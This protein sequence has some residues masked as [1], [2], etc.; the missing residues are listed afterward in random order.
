MRRHKL[1]LLTNFPN[2]GSMTEGGMSA[3]EWMF[4]LLTFYTAMGKLSCSPEIS[5]L[6]AFHGLSMYR[7]WQ[8][9]HWLQV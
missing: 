7:L 4:M 2:S 1:A 6:P 3:R 5:S 9:A 8:D